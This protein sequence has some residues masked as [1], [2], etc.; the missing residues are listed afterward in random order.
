MLYYPLRDNIVD[1]PRYIRVS[2]K[3]LIHSLIPTSKCR[4]MCYRL[5][6]GKYSLKRWV[7]LNSALKFV[8]YLSDYIYIYN[9]YYSNYYDWTR[10]N[11]IDIPKLFYMNQYDIQTLNDWM[12]AEIAI[13][14]DVSFTAVARQLRTSPLSI[15]VQSLHSGVLGACAIARA[16]TPKCCRK[17]WTKCIHTCASF[18]VPFWRHTNIDM[19]DQ[20]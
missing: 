19:F 12:L 10:W 2:F 16:L 3:V 5:I 18:H 9:H 8:R 4:F 1:N 20:G 17:K 7:D 6:A 15:V 14:G 11:D 13:G